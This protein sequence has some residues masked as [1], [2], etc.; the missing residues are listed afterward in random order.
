VESL[1]KRNVAW[2]ALAGLAMVVCVGCGSPG[3]LRITVTRSGTLTPASGYVLMS[4]QGSTPAI[5]AD[6]NGK[7]VWRYNFDTHANSY[8]PIPI[9]PLPNGDLI[10]ESAT[11]SGIAP[12]S[13]CSMN[14]V[15]EEISVSGK[16]IW[17]LSNQQLQQELTT[18]GYDITLGQ[19]SHDAIGLPNGN[20][21]VLASDLRDIPGQGNQIE[22]AVL[23]ELDQD[24]EPVWVWDAFDHLDVTRHP[25]FALPDWIHGN[26][27]IYSKDDGNLLFSSRAQS[28]VMKLDFENGTGSG[29]VLWKL[30]Y[31]GDFTLTNGGTADWF[32]AQH[33]PI[34]LSPNTTGVF[35]LGLFDNGNSRVL[36]ADGA[37]CGDSG[38]PVC[39]SSVPI[40]QIDEANRTATVLWRDKLEF[41]SSA[42]GNMQV[43]DNGDVWFDAGFVSANQAIIRE[44]TMETNPQMVLE[45][46]VNQVVYR[47]IHLP[48]SELGLH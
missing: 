16:I 25:Y 48:G 1:T 20:I 38:Q 41:F 37:M 5:A 46:D 3:D 26:A 15:L 8:H 9:Q 28:W 45:M 29:A 10:I 22:G 24:H 18:A 39:Y 4:S 40:F 23:V 33:A 43:L 7:I 35:Q 30:G 27:V 21:I 17:Q 42:V 2:F 14:N 12:C 6:L 47:A 32:Y 34:F 44:V 19:M 36:N 11:G 31:Q 13:D